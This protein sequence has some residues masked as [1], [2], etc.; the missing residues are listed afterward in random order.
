MRRSWLALVLVAAMTATPLAVA[1]ADARSDQAKVGK[2]IDDR[3]LV[4][5]GKWTSKASAA[6]FQKTLSKSK[7]KGARLT[8]K[9]STASGGA[10]SFQAGPD[11]GKAQVF[12]G[13]VK[14]AT[15]KTAA[16][17]KKTKVVQ[18]TGSGKVV[19][20]VK[21]PGKKGVY[22]DVVAL[23]D[24]GTP[25]STT[26]HPGVGEVIFTEWLAEPTNLSSADGEWF[27]LQNVAEDAWSLDGCTVTDGESTSTLAAADMPGSNIFVFARNTNVAANGGV[28]AEGAYNLTLTANDSLTLTCG[29]TLIDTV[30]WTTVTEGATL[31]LDPDHYSATQ[32]DLAAN[33]CLG[34]LAY[35]DGGDFGT[36]HAGNSQ[37]P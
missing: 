20:K 31:S 8:T 15:V 23:N 2:I 4:R 27:E 6:A 21:S 30:T 22:V 34:S 24:V 13:G 33:Y 11:R 5:K 16:N 19:V 18:F 28:T 9:E 14:K 7:V 1:A 3:D 32:N 35:G 17:K 10:V 25:P 26:P 36:P 29:A 37:C 12:V